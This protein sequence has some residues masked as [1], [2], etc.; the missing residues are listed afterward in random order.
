MGNAPIN[1]NSDPA[2]STPGITIRL[3][4]RYMGLIQLY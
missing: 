4:F 2:P 3:M 1:V